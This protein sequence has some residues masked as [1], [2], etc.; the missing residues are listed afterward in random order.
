MNKKRII[1]NILLL[2]SCGYFYVCLEL[3]YRHYSTV[4]MMFCASLAAIPMLLLNNWFTYDMYYIWQI[5]ICALFATGVE[6]IFGIIFNRDF[7]IWDYRNQWGNIQGMICPL[8]TLLWGLISAGMIV[9]LDWIEYNIFDDP[10]RPYYVITRK[11]II[12]MKEK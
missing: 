10:I 11:W 4:E 7:H 8:F 5:M 12:Y 6:Y 2:M 3:I 1:T 9:L